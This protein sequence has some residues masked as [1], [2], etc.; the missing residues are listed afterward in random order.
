MNEQNQAAAY[1]PGTGRLKDP[2]DLRRAVK[3]S[4]MALAI[5]KGIEIQSL[6]ETEPAKNRT[7]PAGCQTATSGRSE[8]IR[9]RRARWQEHP[10]QP[11]ATGE[12]KTNSIVCFPV[13][14][15]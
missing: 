13:W 8:S 6:P 14:L 11:P 4:I 5:V 15:P 9:S 3:N 1:G 10:F 2:G 7:L 12:E